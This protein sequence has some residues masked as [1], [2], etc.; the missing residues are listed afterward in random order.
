MLEVLLVSPLDP[1]RAKNLKLLVG[2]ENTHTWTLL[3]YPPAGV[4]YTHY[5][6]ALAQGD[7]RHTIWQEMLSNL[8]RLRI[9]PPDAGY[10][11]F[12]LH[13]RFDLIHA[14]SYSV[15]IDG[16]FKPPVILSASSS[17]F[18]FLRDYLG[19]SVRRIRFQYR[20]RKTIH[21]LFNVYDPELNQKD[22]HLVLFSRFARKIHQDL[23]QVER[24]ISILF[25]GLP[26][27]VARKHKKKSDGIHLLF[28]GVW[29]ERKGGRFLLEAY[30]KLRL[31]KKNLKL[32]ILGPLP[33]DIKITDN[34]IY[35]HDFV[36]YERLHQEFYHQADILVNVPPVAE[37]FGMVVLEAMSHGVVPVV[38][39]VYAL[40]ELVENGVSGVVVKPG[41]TQSLVT[42]LKKLIRNKKL[43]Q[44]MGQAA[45]VR[46]RR[47]FSTSHRNRKLN[48][49]YAK[50]L[51]TQDYSGN[52]SR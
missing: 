21:N 49:L 4:H 45:Q 13:K 25:P 10:Q 5:H 27:P 22:S 37:G 20:L 43:C 30:Q 3:K 42:S 48:N 9:L 11:C 14:H 8:I 26:V 44:D 33:K 47:L 46:F 36:S 24:N 17:N 18:L 35:Q 2:G 6:E 34:T 1:K 39:A 15:K 52:K 38:S 51:R 32:T 50:V 28:V 7:I 23:G 29:F 31:T 12:S 40:P 16:R 41:D 19:W